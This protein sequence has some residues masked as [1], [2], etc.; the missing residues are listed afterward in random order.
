MLG[1]L[2]LM[3]PASSL[4]A[5]GIEISPF[6][7][8][9]FGNDFFELIAGQPI[10]TDGAPAF[11]VTVDVPLYNGLQ[12]EGQ[13]SRQRATVMAP[14]GPFGQPENWHITVDDWLAGGL[15]EYATGR[16]RP[17]A[18]GMVGLTR[19]AGEGDS[20]IR[21]TLSGGGGVKLFPTSRLGVRLNGQIFSTFVYAN[22]TARACGPGVCLTHVTV[23]LVWQIEFTAALI[24]KVF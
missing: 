11:G 7:G 23:D 19:Y 8:Y 17:F 13:V 22:A 20:E 4:C 5:Q 24:V 21:F 14:V 2:C 1:L 9:R 6:G 12:V 10:D 3:G 18:I 15:Q 16:A